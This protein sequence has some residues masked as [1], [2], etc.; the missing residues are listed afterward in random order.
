M[1]AGRRPHRARIEPI[2][3]TGDHQER[4][5]CA[6]QR[7]LERRRFGEIR[8]SM[9]DVARGGVAR[10]CNDL[11]ARGRERSNEWSTDISSRSDDCEHDANLAIAI[12]VANR[13]RDMRCAF[14]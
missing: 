1:T 13:D 3:R 2:A 11:L 9:L 7:G 8:D 5:S 10:D 14:R 12:S 6:S 4:R